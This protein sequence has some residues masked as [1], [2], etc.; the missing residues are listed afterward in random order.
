MDQQPAPAVSLRRL[1]VRY[2]LRLAEGSTVRAGLRRVLHP[3][4]NGNDFWALRDLSFDVGRGEAVGIIGSNGA[5]KSTLL[6][7]LARIV[8]PSAGEMTIRG[9]VTSLLTL[10]AGFDPNLS[11]RQNIELVGTLLRLTRSEILA[12][13]D[14]IVAFADIGQFIDAP[15]RTY[16][17]GMRARLGFAISTAADPDILL[18]DEVMAAGDAGF[19]EKSKERVAELVAMAGA[20]IVVSHDLGWVSSFCS[21]ALL[22]EGGRVAVDGPAI[23]VVTEYRRRVRAARLE[24]PRLTLDA[25]G[26][27]P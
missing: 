18:L 26:V 6:Q 23:D 17:A 27:R 21:R 11:G 12:R 8:D 25:Q 24:S 5:G 15:V 3:R 7:V 9:R 13:R 4:R 16:S 14:E 22:L 19:R 1:G 20:V 2:D 10:G